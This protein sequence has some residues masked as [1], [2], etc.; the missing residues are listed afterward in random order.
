MLLAFRNCL[1]YFALRGG[2]LLKNLIFQPSAAAI[3][4][5]TVLIQHSNVSNAT[6]SSESKIEMT[7]EG[8]LADSAINSERAWPLQRRTS[9]RLMTFNLQELSLVNENKNSEPSNQHQPNTKSKNKIKEIQSLIQKNQPDIILLQEVLNQTS[10]ELLNSKFLE[11][12][13]EAVFIPGHKETYHHVAYLIRKTLKARWSWDSPGPIQYQ[14]PDG[15][16]LLYNR[17]LPTLH[18]SS[19]DQ[20]RIVFIL[21]YHGISG[22]KKSDQSLYKAVQEEQIRQATD[23]MRTLQKKYHTQNPLIILGGDFNFDLER[24]NLL[25]HLQPDLIEAFQLLANPL[26]FHDTYTFFKPDAYPHFFQRLDGFIINQT[27]RIKSLYTPRFSNEPRTPEEFNKRG[28]ADLASDHNPVVL[29][30]FLRPFN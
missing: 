22:R 27:T 29:D 8:A 10:L 11:N 9:L 5:L 18:L 19:P 30:I 14:Y 2:P 7:C 25:A 13:Y 6:A 28:R 4:I 26:P 21:N 15:S 20:S 3:I 1:K 24:S 16:M 23:F 17:D 12:K